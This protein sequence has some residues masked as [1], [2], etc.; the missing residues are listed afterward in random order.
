MTFPA[1][2][3]L[4]GVVARLNE[5]AI[6]DWRVSFLAY[7]SDTAAE[8]IEVLCHQARTIAGMREALILARR[9]I[10]ATP[11]GQAIESILYEIDEALALSSQDG[12]EASD[13]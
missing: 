5:I 11:H 2:E 1:T 3:P 4:A 9:E 8:A 12:K 6:H 13:A 7:T 10:M